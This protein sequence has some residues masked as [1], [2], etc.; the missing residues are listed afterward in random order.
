MFMHEAE[1]ACEA[2]ASQGI[3]LRS[4]K[5]VLLRH[6]DVQITNDVLM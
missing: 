4:F 1:P 2:P 6:M 3:A 5:A